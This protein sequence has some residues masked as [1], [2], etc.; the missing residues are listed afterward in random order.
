MRNI[1][2]CLA[3]YENPTMLDVQIAN[4]ARLPGELREAV[5]LIVVDDCSP[6]HPA[7]FPERMPVSAKLYRMRVDIPWNQDACRNLAVRE[8]ETDWVLLT[9]MDH[10]P[11]ER[12][13]ARLVRE[14]L[15]AGNAYTFTRVNVDG[16]SYK[17][18]P[19][20]WCMTRELYD[21]A[22]GYD[23]RFA[24]IYG[25]DGMFAGRLRKAAHDVLELPVPLVRYS[26]D[27][28][29][30]AST[31]PSVLTRKSP[32]NDRKRQALKDEI[33]LTPGIRTVRGRFQWDRVR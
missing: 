14:G 4:L 18:H 22:G 25:T 28:V 5:S 7:K 24:G 30:D 19:N 8:A 2:L 29:P 32:E 20:S 17:P 10:M 1:T 16:S 11:P 12:T 27:D 33:R 21:L 9:D 15:Y 23:E 26:R 3:Y 6:K 13:L 31:H